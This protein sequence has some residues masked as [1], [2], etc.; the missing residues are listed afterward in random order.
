[1]MKFMNPLLRFL[2][3]GAIGF[4]AVAIF[5]SNAYIAVLLAV[6]CGVTLDKLFKT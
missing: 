4:Y 6:V 1:M 5:S 3:G 2:I